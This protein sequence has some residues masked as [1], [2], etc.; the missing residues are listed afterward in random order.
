MSEVIVARRGSDTPTETQPPFELRGDPSKRV[1]A[2]GLA[3]YFAQLRDEGYT[4]VRDIATPEF[5]AHLR[6]TCIRLAQE[7]TG[8]AKGHAA[9][10]LLGRDPIFEEVVLN[11][12]L[13]ALVEVMC[14]RGTTINNSESASFGTKN[15]RV[16]DSQ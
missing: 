5:T 11:P 16:W 1:A 8:M 12:K 3:D 10:M 15:I 4:A 13:L 6:E 14:G 7:T 2:L 9:G